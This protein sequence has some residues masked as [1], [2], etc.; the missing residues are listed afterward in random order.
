MLAEYDWCVG[1][2]LLAVGEL[3]LENNSGLAL[4]FGRRLNQ[5]FGRRLRQEGRPLFPLV[6]PVQF[7]LFRGYV[8]R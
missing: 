7:Y 1:T 5:E 6:L 3:L 4:K 8:V 2:S